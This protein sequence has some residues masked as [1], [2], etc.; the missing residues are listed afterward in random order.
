MSKLLVTLEKINKGS[1]A[2]LGFGT[3]SRG[4]RTSSMALIGR[5][6]RN[7]N[8]GAK[9]LAK[10]GA[11]G[12]L[13]E[14]DDLGSK[15]SDVIRALGAVPWGICATELDAEKTD[16]FAQKGCD[17]FL[18]N[19]NTV[20]VDALKDDRV[21]YILE[22]P[23]DPDEGMLRA[24]E[25]LPVDVVFMSF[26]SVETPLV[27]QHL[28]AI[29]S[30]RSSFDKYIALEVPAGLS[31]KEVELLR[32]VGVDALV[33]DAASSSEKEISSLKEILLRVPRQ[34]KSRS[35]KMSPVLP[36]GSFDASSSIQEGDDDDF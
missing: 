19:A 30:A 21:A 15:L 5:L 12:A 36:R 13:L 17:F 10:M 33:I 16:E 28:I 2:R 6:S 31:P 22:L 18:V 24:I 20:T 32:D 25:D 26:G 9:R 27:L 11:D 14:G 4:E 34:R 8:Q 3:A 29:C 23:P 35:E 1:P 7:Y